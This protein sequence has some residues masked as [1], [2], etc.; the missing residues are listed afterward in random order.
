MELIFHL[1]GNGVSNIATVVIP[2]EAQFSNGN[3]LGPIYLDQQFFWLPAANIFVNK[4]YSDLHGPATDPD[5]I[6]FQP[7]TFDILN[8]NG[9]GDIC[10]IVVVPTDTGHVTFT[11]IML[12]PA[13]VLEAITS[14]LVGTVEY[15]VNWDVPTFIVEPCPSELMGDVNTSA[16]ITSTDVIYLVNYVFKGGPAPLPTPLVGDADCSRSITSADIIWMVNY[17]FRSGPLPCPCSGA[18]L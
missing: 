14:D 3:I 2:I 10:K 1:D 16:D 15:D 17:L 7:L 5:T 8:W 4:R 9:A 6:F 18:G 11:D 12:P 13:N